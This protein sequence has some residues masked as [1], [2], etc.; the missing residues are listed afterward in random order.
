MGR[1]HNLWPCLL[2]EFCFNY[3]SCIVY[4]IC[5]NSTALEQKLFLRPITSLFIIATL[6]IQSVVLFYRNEKNG[7]GK[8]V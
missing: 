1:F 3:A 7:N 2:F 6:R 8:S 4:S 5:E